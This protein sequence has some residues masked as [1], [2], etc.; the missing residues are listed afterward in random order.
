MHQNK[1]LISLRKHGFSE[2]P[3]APMPV[4]TIG[5]AA[6]R[7]NSLSCTSNSVSFN[8][9][10]LGAVSTHNITR[11][12]IAVNKAISAFFLCIG[13]EN[14]RMPAGK[15]RGAAFGFGKGGTGCP[16]PRTDRPPPGWRFPPS[17]A[18]RP[19][20]RRR[21]YRPDLPDPGRGGQPAPPVP[22]HPPLDSCGINAL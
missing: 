13:R 7:T 16:C 8:V 12:W 20:G 19:T 5:T 9:R 17:A 21:R 3:P 11:L 1:P 6:S 18:S 4:V 2:Q 14:R 22:K 15:G 10:P